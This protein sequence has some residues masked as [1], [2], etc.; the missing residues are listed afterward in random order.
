MARVRLIL[1][2]D[3]GA[4]LNEHWERVYDLGHNL[5][6]LD[7]IAA[8]ATQVRQQALPDLQADLLAAAQKRALAEEKKRPDGPATD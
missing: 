7:L 3:D 4:L 6:R 2:D 8:A 5:K 1:E